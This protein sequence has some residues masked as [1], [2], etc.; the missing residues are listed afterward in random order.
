V[1]RNLLTLF[2]ALALRPTATPAQIVAAV[3][4][5]LEYRWV[6]EGVAGHTHAAPRPAMNTF[7]QVSD[8]VVLTL[9]GVDTAQVADRAGRADVFIRL[10]PDASQRFAETTAAHI[11]RELAVLINDSVV[12]VVTIESRLSRVAGVLAS[13]GPDS[14][15]AVAAR[16]NRA[17]GQPPRD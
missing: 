16:I 8:S 10:T 14:A 11:G 3:P 12:Q 1:I 4:F 7:V 5:T 2:V 9:T 13:V 15:A 17:R 6:G